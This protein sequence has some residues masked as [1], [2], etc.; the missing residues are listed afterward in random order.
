MHNDSLTRQLLAELLA[1]GPLKG[2]QLAQRLRRAYEMQTGQP[3]E[4][5]RW[6]FESFSSFLHAHADVALIARPEGEGDVEVSLKPVPQIERNGVAERGGRDDP[7]PQR[8]P[9]DI[10]QAFTNP[11]PN[12]RRYF[13]RRTGEVAHYRNGASDIGDE[14][15]RGRVEAWG[16]DAALINPIAATTQ[17]GWMRDFVASLSLRAHERDA[18]ERLLDTSYTSSLN[19]VF[20]RTLGSDGPGWRAY[21]SRRVNEYVERWAEEN[22]IP[23]ERLVEGRFRAPTVSP[24][25]LS[26]TALGVAP[27]PGHFSELRRKLHLLIDALPDDD[28]EK[29]LV[30]LATVARL[31]DRSARS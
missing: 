23:F 6:G 4:L 15:A 25:D 3:F 8:L 18:L 5:A 17:H 11:D 9:A 16:N 27:Q 28:V 19:L 26:S 14:K 31:I 10:W 12:R 7:R 1:S 2:A 13:N 21:R 24:P 20:S 29:V 30:P 22:G